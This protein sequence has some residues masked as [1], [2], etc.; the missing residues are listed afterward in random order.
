MLSICINTDISTKPS[1]QSNKTDKSQ[2]VRISIYKLRL[3]SLD[4]KIFE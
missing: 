4:Y 2:L 3:Y 1:I